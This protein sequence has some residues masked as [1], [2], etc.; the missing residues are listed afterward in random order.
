[1]GASQGAVDW[2]RKAGRSYDSTRTS[3]KP[4]FQQLEPPPSYISFRKVPIFLDAISTSPHPTSNHMDMGGGL[5]VVK[6]IMRVVTGS[7]RE[8]MASLLYHIIERVEA[9]T[10]LKEVLDRWSKL[11]INISKLWQLK[12]NIL[13]RVS[14]F[15]RFKQYNC[16]HNSCTLL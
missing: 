1:M 3:A 12:S 8:D 2:L 7:S 9:F 4:Y 16:Y 15:Y 13:F 14:F 10:I 5:Q 11:N 6:E